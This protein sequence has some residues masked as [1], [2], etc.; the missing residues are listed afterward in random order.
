MAPGGR[1]PFHE[2]IHAGTFAI[3][4]LRVLGKE[5]YEYTVETQGR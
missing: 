2:A 4:A 3:K 1:F 5:R